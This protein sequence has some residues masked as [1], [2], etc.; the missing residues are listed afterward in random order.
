[1]TTRNQHKIVRIL[2]R[3]VPSS[4]YWESTVECKCGPEDIMLGEI[5]DSITGAVK[6]AEH[7]FEQHLAWIGKH[8]AFTTEPARR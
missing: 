4:D 8:E 2:I 1:M 7:R 5:A 3:P 6:A